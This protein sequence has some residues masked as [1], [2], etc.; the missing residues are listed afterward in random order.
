MLV[1]AGVAIGPA[2]AQNPAD[3]AAKMLLTSARKGYNDKQYSFASARF[4]EFLQKFGGHKEANAARYGLALA[5]LDGPEKDRNLGEAAQLLTTAGGDGGF[6]DRAFAL[7]WLGQV[8][9]AQGMADL[10]VAAQPGKG[11][12]EIAKYQKERCRSSRPRLNTFNR[13][14]ILLKPLAKGPVGDKELP[15]SW[16]WVARTRADIAEMQLR[17]GK[18]KDARASRRSR[19]SRTRRCRG[20]RYRD[21]GRYCYAHAAFLAGDMPTAQKTLTMLAPFASPEWGTH[22]RYLL[23]RT[24]HQAGEWAEATTQYEAT[25]A[26]YKK[27]IEDA[28]RAL[29]GQEPARRRPG[30]ASPDRIRSPRP[31]AGS[32]RAVDVLSRRA[33]L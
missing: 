21:F 23:A 29:Q 6:G 19:F 18:P 1:L 15:E 33:S 3:Q 9:R 12:A 8:Q 24:H 32:R 25:I 31:G 27:A 28:G 7:Y 30:P 26:G 20:S 13:A 4:R 22:A 17:V 11:P 10:A 5:L 14:A 16:E 2:F